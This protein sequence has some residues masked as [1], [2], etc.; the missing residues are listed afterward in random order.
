MKGHDQP[1]APVGLAFALPTGR[2]LEVALRVDR[3]VVQVDL[4]R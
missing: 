3:G 1:V 4:L 2:D